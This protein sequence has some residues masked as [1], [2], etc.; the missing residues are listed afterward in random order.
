MPEDS[1]YYS[2]KEKPNCDNILSITISA[3]TISCIIGYFI[4]LAIK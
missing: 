1:N 3:I 4:Y 2:L